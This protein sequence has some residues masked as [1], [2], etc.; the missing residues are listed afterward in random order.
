MCERLRAVVVEPITLPFMRSTLRFF[1]LAACAVSPL[2]ARPAPSPAPSK[3]LPF[4]HETSDLTPDPAAHFGTLANGLRYVVRPNPEP[5]GRASLRL[6]VLAGSL[7]ETDDQRGLAHFLEH[8]AFNGSTHYAPGT[9]VEFFQRMGMSFGGDT[10]ANT[11]F[12]RTIYLLELPRADDATVAEGLRVFRDYAGGLLLSDEEIERERGVILSEKRVSD[13]VGFRTFRARF[14]AMLGT[15]RLPR[16]VP[17]G[18]P[19]VIEH[20]PRERFADFWNTW[21]RPEKMLV[22]AVGDFADPAAVEKIISEAFEG[23]TPRAPA[24][25]DPSLGKLAKFEGVRAIFHAEPEAPATNVSLTSITPYAHE[26]DTAARQIKRVPRSL[27]LAMLNRRF[28]ILAKKEDAPFVS[29]GASVSESFDFLRDASVHISCKPEQWKAALAV[30]EEEL[31]RALQHGFT[32][33]ELQEATANMLNRLEQAEKTV[34][35]RHSSAVADEIVETVL[36]GDVLTTPADDLKLIKPVLEKITPAECV[37]ELKTAFEAKGRFVMVTGNVLIEGDASAAIKSAYQQAH[38]VAVKAPAADETGAW[39]YTDFGPPGEIEHREHIDDLDLELVTFKNGVRLNLKKTDFEAGRISLSARVGNG[40]ITEPA[41]QPGL[42]ALAGG[43][44]TAGGLGKHSADD[45][46]N[47]LAGKNVGWSFSTNYD[48]LS[49]S[50]GTT[51]ADLLL[52]FQLLTAELMDPGYRPEALRVARK[53]LEQMYLSFAH[54]ASGPLATE[55]ARLLASGDRRFGM[56]DKPVMLAR[57]LEEVK[58]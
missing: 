7:Q 28:S 36:D 16:R 4:P 37:A 54:T 30:G 35:T 57:N 6:M 39:A 43:T 3:S 19:A 41:Q 25:P 18:E 56:P 50:G 31:R 9:L 15:T 44:F 34:S 49:F 11:S 46:R 51:Q 47:L 38:A 21:Y 27:A 26:Q 14:E 10:N 17:I 5:K 13:S 58:A 32:P 20:A 23:L 52:E 48:T 2:A 12:D 1:L 53:G 8:M 29:A 24:R 55:V 45:L 42:S 22:V 40:A 33:A